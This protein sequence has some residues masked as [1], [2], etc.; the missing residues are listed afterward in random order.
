MDWEF[1][2]WDGEWEGRFA[3]GFARMG[4]PIHGLETG[5]NFGMNEMND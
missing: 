3:H 1:W 2:I 5:G 4:L